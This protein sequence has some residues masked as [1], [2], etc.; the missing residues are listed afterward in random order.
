[1][2]E[3]VTGYID[4]V[5]F[6]N[7][8]NGYTVM[9][10]KGMEEEQELTCV[11]TFPAITQ[12]A[13][14]EATGNYITHPVYGKQ[15]QISSYTEKMPEDALAMERY[16]GSGA[17]KGIGAALAARIVRRFG[18][19]TMRIVEEEPERLAEIKGI[20]EKKALEI[21]EQMT[22]KADMRRAMVF[23]QKYGISLNLGAKIYQKYGQSVY[24]VLQENPYRLAE[25]IS[26][27][28]FRIA[29][30]IASRIGIHTDSDYRIRS[31][32]LYTL[33]QASGEGHIYLPKEE[34]FSRASKLLGVDV[35]YMEK[36]LMD[37]VVD[38]KLILKE[39]EEGIVVYPTQYYYL[40]LNSA[41]MLCE[42]N[43]LCPED[44]QMMKKRIS[45]IEKETG[46]ELDEM[47]KQAVASAAQHGLFILTGGPGTGKTTTI[48]A[49]IRYFEEEGAEL[50]LA[51]PTGRA[52]KR[53]TEATGYEAQT[54]H[55]LLELNGL[56]EGE[57]EG[58]AV[59][60]DRNSENPLEAD[61]II[62]DEMSM[63]DISLM[64]SL[65]LAVTAGT[66]LILVGDENQLPSVGPG[67]VLRDIIRSG[68]FPVVELKKIFRQASE[69]DIVVNAHKINRGEQVTINNKSRDFFFLKRYDADIIIRVVIALIQ[70]KLPRYVDAK[71]YEIQVLT[72]M[73]KG[74]LGVERLNQILQRYL[75]PPDEKKKEKE[76]GQ[77]LFREGDKVMQVKNNYQLEWEILGRYKIP[78]DKGV[79]VFNGDTG[80]MTEINEFAETATVEFED[81]RQAQYS[82]KQ[83][84]E[85]ELAYAVTIHKSQGSE[86]PAVILP[87]LSGP[88]M[89][90]N[91][92]LLYTAV[93]RARKC[94]TVVGSE[95]TF[96][97]M[98][99]NEKQQQRYSSLDKRIRELDELE[100]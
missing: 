100:A 48:N 11:G 10:L 45:R 65:L 16:L 60:F 67:N 75:N 8:D 22:E 26:G 15:F 56:P 47:Q 39:T 92:N 41:K 70:E 80:I 35:S 4:H 31:G 21:A 88:R 27:V 69:S 5:I 9:V 33:L 30:E 84:E 1:M 7:D 93:T 87:I 72:P 89:L 79:G 91:R 34:L 52:A 46:T 51:A 82:F 58:R 32:M 63:V 77:R 94:V 42:L 38:R 13:S 20:S 3:T 44:E 95:N 2:S 53:M 99:R 83:L 50:R 28:G 68:C 96:A 90:M 64:Y 14:I 49:I 98:I 23:L 61:V 37:M 25:D 6:R 62:I 19:D 85:L 78:V 40:E 97:E 76:I 43:I 18:N 66:R 54:I 55:R 59:H 86:Y 12:G 73:R 71:P 17:I 36:H 57:Q 24:G 81:G 74:L 29:D